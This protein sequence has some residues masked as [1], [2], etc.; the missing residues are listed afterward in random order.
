MWDSQA[1]INMKNRIRWGYEGS[2]SHKGIVGHLFIHADSKSA[3][4]GRV[5]QPV[6][7]ALITLVLEEVLEKETPHGYFSLS[8]VNAVQ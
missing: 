1:L 6:R 8:R 3:A 5:T 2:V 7:F 4:T